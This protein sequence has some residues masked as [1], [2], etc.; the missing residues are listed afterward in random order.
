MLS[1]DH[2]EW[3][4]MICQIKSF[5]VHHNHMSSATHQMC[6]H[7]EKRQLLGKSLFKVWYLGKGEGKDQ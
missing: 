6:A 3:Y 4:D 1:Y 2:L 5:G 7:D